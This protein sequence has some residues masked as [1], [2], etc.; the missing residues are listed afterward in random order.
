MNMAPDSGGPRRR[1]TFVG[2]MTL[3][4]LVGCNG[5]GTDIILTTRLPMDAPPGQNEQVMYDMCTHLG[6]EKERPEDAL[7]VKFVDSNGVE[8]ERIIRC[9]SVRRKHKPK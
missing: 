7:K 2:A 3:L 1:T 5:E 8:S 4:A 9:E 6:K